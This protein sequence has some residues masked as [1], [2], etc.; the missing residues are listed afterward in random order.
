MNCV[1]TQLATSLA[2]YEARSMQINRAFAPDA[3]V[4]TFADR[5]HGFLTSVILDVKVIGRSAPQV[6]SADRSMAMAE[7][8]RLL[9]EVGCLLGR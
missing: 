5:R 6:D 9:R 7:I 2:A 8:D 4:V 1:V 3:S